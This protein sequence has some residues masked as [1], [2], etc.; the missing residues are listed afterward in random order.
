MIL[1][2]RAGTESVPTLICQIIAS[3]TESDIRLLKSKEQ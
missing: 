1:H 3:T 2:I